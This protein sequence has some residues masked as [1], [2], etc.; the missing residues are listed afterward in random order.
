[1]RDPAAAIVAHALHGAGRH[2][3]EAAFVPD[4]ARAGREDGGFLVTYVHEDGATASEMV[5]YDA[6]SMTRVARVGL[7]ARVP[8]GF[9]VAHV[10]EAALR[11]Q[12]EE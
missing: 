8:Y 3:G 11:G 6:A 12:V 7:P 9:H 1:M 10:A 2:G 5:V 4:P